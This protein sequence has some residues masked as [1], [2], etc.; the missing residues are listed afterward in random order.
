LKRR[1][2]YRRASEAILRQY[3]EKYNCATPDQQCMDCYNCFIYGGVIAIKDE[4]EAIK[5]RLKAIT[6]FSIQSDEEA[7]ID[8]EEFHNIVHTDFRMEQT[9]KGQ[10]K[11]SIYT[12]VLIKPGVV[13]PF[14]DI[15]FN[16]SQFDISMYLEMLRRADAMGF[17]SRSSL[18]GTMETKIIAVTDNLT[19]SHKDLLTNIE[20]SET[21]DVSYEKLLQQFSVEELVT[22]EQLT[23][24]REKLP[25][26]I[27]TYKAAIYNAATLK[28]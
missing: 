27:E 26:L 5:S 3:E 24:I 4:T 25:N 13:F 10:K 21:G 7:L 20:L 12:L 2:V 16:P 23:A 18:L 1:G 11:P 19:I 8:E 22:D 28:A 15:I 14:I 17:G 9:D 6:A